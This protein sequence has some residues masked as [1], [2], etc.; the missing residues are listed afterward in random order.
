MDGNTKHNSNDYLRVERHPAIVRPMILTPN[1]KMNHKRKKPGAEKDKTGDYKAANGSGLK[2][3]ASSTKIAS[4]EI[5]F[6]FYQIYCLLL[7]TRFKRAFADNIILCNIYDSF[8][9]AEF[10][11]ST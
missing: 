10:L 9:L 8:R 11:T 4:V 2:N 5:K 3:H 7:F 1:C 6:S